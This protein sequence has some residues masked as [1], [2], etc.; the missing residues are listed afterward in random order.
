MSLNVKLNRALPDN[1]PY[2]LRKTHGVVITKTYNQS[3]VFIWM[4]VQF[5]P[6]SNQSYQSEWGQLCAF[7]FA[8]YLVIIILVNIYWHWYSLF[9]YLFW[10]TFFTVTW[11]RFVNFKSTLNQ[12]IMINKPLH[13]SASG[14]Q[15]QSTFASS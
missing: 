9:L 13:S 10:N 12:I 15:F 5:F 6:F 1:C 2:R 4:Y 7:F 8:L 3:A 14:N 11:S